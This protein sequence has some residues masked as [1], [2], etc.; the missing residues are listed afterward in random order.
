MRKNIFFTVSCAAALASAAGAAPS[1]SPAVP[2]SVTVRAVAWDYAWKPATEKE[3][4][5]RVVA[6]VAA[7][8]KDGAD[9]VVFPE[10]FSNGR[11]LDGVLSEVRDAAGA[12]RLVVLGNAPHREPGSDHALSRAYILSGGAWQVMDK[13]DPTPAERAQKPPVKEIG[14]ASCRERV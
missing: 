1:K 13:V 14:R 10:Q 6:E 7:A 8:A 4:G 2:D 3:W 12:D 5:A 11:S 9:I